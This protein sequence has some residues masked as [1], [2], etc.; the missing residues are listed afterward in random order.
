MFERFLD[1][2]G[3]VLKKKYQEQ[4]TRLQKLEE[5]LCKVKGTTVLLGKEIKC[6]RKEIKCL[7]DEL[8]ST[9]KKYRKL[10]ELDFEYKFNS[11][12]MYEWSSKVKEKANFRCDI[13]NFIGTKSELEAHHLYPKHIHVSMMYLVDNGVCL[14][15]ECHKGLH[16]EQPTDTMTH[17]SY[18]KF[19]EKRKHD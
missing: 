11:T 17:L 6:L 5:K 9:K 19:R 14:C 1:K 8:K 3:L 16:D 2:V 4:I 18:L 15:K 10:D 7:N 13:C 12:K